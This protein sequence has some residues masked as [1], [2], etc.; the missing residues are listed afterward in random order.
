MATANHQHY[1]AMNGQ[2]LRTDQLNVGD[3]LETFDCT[4][5]HDSPPDNAMP[6]WALGWLGVML[7]DGCLRREDA[8]FTAH[9]TIGYCKTSRHSPQTHTSSKWLTANTVFGSNPLNARITHW[10]SSLKAEKLWASKVLKFVPQRVFRQGPAERAYFLRHIWNCDGTVN[11]CGRQAVYT[12]I[13]R[14]LAYDIKQLLWSIGIPASLGDYYGTCGFT[15]RMV[16]PTECE[17]QEGL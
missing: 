5:L 16:P 12:T 3:I 6:L 9:Q 4:S 17:S 11:E 7:G 14:T 2:L 15:G 8:G 10:F 13:S 1:L